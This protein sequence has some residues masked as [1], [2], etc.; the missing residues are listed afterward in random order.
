MKIFHCLHQWLWESYFKVW[1]ILYSVCKIQKNKI[2]V[3]SYY[4]ADYG[5]NGKY[6]VE[7]LL[8]RSGDLDIVWLLKEE[9]LQKNRLPKGVRGVKY[10]SRQSVYELQTAGVWIDNSRKT[11]GWKRKGQYYIQTWHGD[12]GLKRIEKDVEEVLAPS[13]VRNAKKD[14]AMADAMVSGNAWFTGKIRDAFWYD[15][16]IIK[17]GYPRRDILY[18]SQEHLQQIKHTMGL[19]ENAKVFFYAPTFRRNQEELGVTIYTLNWERVLAAAQTQF[20]GEWVGIIRLH[21]NIS[22]MASML[23]LPPNVFD[24][25]LYPDMQELLAVSDICISDYSSSVFE[26]AVTRKPAFIYANDVADYQQDRGTYFQFSE[27][28]F[29][30]AQNEEELVE[31]I[32]S[33]GEREY[34]E[35]CDLF[36]NDT[37]G[38]Y[39]EGHASAELVQIKSRMFNLPQSIS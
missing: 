12:I 10:R 38:M 5:D 14:S 4:G 6:I 1:G 15:G 11:Y 16:E 21:P 37:L 31:N 35:K 3:C 33:F 8:R 25:T 29:A 36:Y 28:P 7:E 18:G 23:E 30:V 9:L 2:V 19:P 13:Y 22:H 39:P 20:G 27:L 32:L 17:C 24:M 26:F 34:R